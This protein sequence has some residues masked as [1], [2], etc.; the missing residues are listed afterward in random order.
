MYLIQHKNG[1]NSLGT[2]LLLAE[3]C[4]CACVCVHA[5]DMH[6]CTL[7][8]WLVPLLWYSVIC[9]SAADHHANEPNLLFMPH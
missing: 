4:A 5:C 8:S 7:Q 6:V 2:G 9:S 1:P 3:L